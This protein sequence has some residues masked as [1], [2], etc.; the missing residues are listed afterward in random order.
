MI[1]LNKP[2]AEECGPE[3]LHL[4]SCPCPLTTPNGRW[5]GPLA[6]GAAERQLSGR[7]PETGVDPLQIF[8]QQSTLVQMEDAPLASRLAE[9]LRWPIAV[10]GVGA[11]IVVVADLISWVP[12][13]VTVYA[14][15]AIGTAAGALFICAVFD[16]KLQRAVSALNADRR[17]D[18]KRRGWLARL[19]GVGLPLGDRP[20]VAAGWILLV[21]TYYAANMAHRAP[22]AALGFA[23]FFLVRMAQIVLAARNYPTD[24]SNRR[25]VRTKVRS[26]SRTAPGDV[27]SAARSH[28][29]R[30]ASCLRP[31][32]S[33]VPAPRQKLPSD[34]PPV[35][36]YDMEK[37]NRAGVL[38]GLCIVLAVG[39]SSCDATPVL[40]PTATERAI[41]ARF[42]PTKIEV[43]WV[44]DRQVGSERVACGLAKEKVTASTS[45]YVP[46]TPFI[47]RHGKAFVASDLPPSEFDTWGDRFCGPD[48][49]KPLYVR[50]VP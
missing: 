45:L 12:D 17:A 21:V 42:D 6:G 2:A 1:C 40:H 3:G 37:F 32:A 35:T 26:P 7:E 46:H 50:G 23:G 10:T 22:A 29:R 34:R 44:E 28:Q 48:W 47:I 36:L 14:A 13:R 30:P 25:S 19:T 4:A 8:T 31:G 11:A 27:L 16:M 33:V 49:V 9:R 18:A 43:V 41:S 24:G 5:E 20:L 38:T 15:A 39:M